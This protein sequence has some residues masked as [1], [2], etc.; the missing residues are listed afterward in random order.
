VLALAKA[1]GWRIARASL[2]L[3]LIALLGACALNRTAYYPDTLPADLPKTVN[4]NDLPY[5]PQLGDQCGPASLA[6]LLN[7]NGIEVTPEALSDKV[8]IPD[9]NGALTTEMVAR[10]RRYGMLVY[11]V[12]GSLNTLL[13]EL[14]VGHPVLVLQNLGFAF[15]PRWHFSI[16]T[17]YDLNQEVLYQRTGEQHKYKIPFSLFDKTW[18]RAERWAVLVLPAGELPA[19]ATP[20]GLAQAASDLELVGEAVAAAKVYQSLVTNYPNYPLGWF[21]LGNVRYQLTEYVDAREAFYRCAALDS[22]NPS[23]W[24]NLS[25]TLARL[26]CNSELETALRCALSLA[27]NDANINASVRELSALPLPPAHGVCRQRSPVVCPQ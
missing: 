8:Y 15:M 11:P 25:Y 7:A 18:R 14:A 12:T 6:T 16:V 13:R 22:N 5:F 26:G 17:G 10:A 27:T 20:E 24:N 9:K 3:G 21:G 23:V 2:L 19:R 4:L 1:N